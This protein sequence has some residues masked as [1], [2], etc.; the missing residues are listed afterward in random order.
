MII[1][2]DWKDGLEDWRLRVS[3]DY[4]HNVYFHIAAKPGKYDQCRSTNKQ[5]WVEMSCFV[6][7][8]PGDNCDQYV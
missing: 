1:G 8:Y 4:H 3:F 2:I 6:Q 5:V 7:L